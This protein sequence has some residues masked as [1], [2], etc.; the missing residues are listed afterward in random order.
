MVAAVEG[1]AYA[2]FLS[3]FSQQVDLHPALLQVLQ[4]IDDLAVLAS[5]NKL[6]Y[7]QFLLFLLVSIDLLA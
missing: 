1:R 6:L 3:Q 4:L 7:V 5:F 2:E